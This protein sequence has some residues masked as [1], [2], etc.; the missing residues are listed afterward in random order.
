MCNYLFLFSLWLHLA[1]V[2]SMLIKKNFIMKAVVHRNE[3]FS[4]T[5]NKQRDVKSALESKAG[6]GFLTS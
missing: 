5:G 1:T 2:L 3:Y 6:S 4:M